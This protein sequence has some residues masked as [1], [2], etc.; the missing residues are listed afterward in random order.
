MVHTMPKLCFG[1]APSEHSSGR[2]V[3]RKHRRRLARIEARLDAL[4]AERHQHQRTEWTNVPDAPTVNLP[5]HQPVATLPDLHP[6]T[7][8]GDDEDWRT[9]VYL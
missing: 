6:G 3:K 4:E 9:G 1:P 7:W 8:T 5:A 2:T